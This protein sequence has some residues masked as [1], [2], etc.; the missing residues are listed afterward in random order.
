MIQGLRAG[1]YNVSL[2]KKV[3]EGVG[4]KHHMDPTRILPLREGKVRIRLFRRVEVTKGIKEI[5]VDH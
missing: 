2:R 5:T 4:K 1:G 3:G